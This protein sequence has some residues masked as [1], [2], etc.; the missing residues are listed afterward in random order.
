[1]N[2]PALLHRLTDWL[3]WLSGRREAAIYEHDDFVRA[4]TAQLATRLPLVY[5]VLLTGMLVIALAFRGT[6]PLWLNT[7]IPIALFVFTVL[8]IRAW[9]PRS[10][11]VR[12]IPEQRRRLKSLAFRAATASTLFSCWFIVLYPHGNLHQQSAIHFVIAVVTL[13]GILGLTESPRAAVAVAFCSVAPA[14]VAILYYGHPNAPYITATQL[15]VTMLVLGLSLGHYRNFIAMLEAR[16]K[17]TEREAVAMK[18]AERMR[19]R[20]LVDPLTGYANRRAILD[21]LQ[22][23]LL[24]HSQP[25]PWLGLLDLDGFKAVNDT[26]GHAAGDLVIRQVSDRLA[27]SEDITDFGRLGGDEFALLVD[28]ALSEEEA[29]ATF[30]RIIETIAQPIAAGAT[31]IRITGSIGV[32]KTARMAVSECLERADIALYDAKREPGRAV[33]FS[34]SDE[35]AMQQQRRLASDMREADLDAQIEVDFQPIF[36]FDTRRIIAVEALARWRNERAGIVS[37]AVFIAHAEATGRIG[38]LTWTV[39]V[40]ALAQMKRWPAQTDLQ[41]NLSAFDLANE[42]LADKLREE[43]LR[44]KVPPGRIVLEVT[45]TSVITNLRRASAMLEKLREYGFRIALDDFGTGYSSLAYLQDLPLD[46]IKID[47]EFARHLTKRKRSV[48]IA[49]TIYALAQQL[50]IDCTIEGIESHSQ[51]AI[52]RRI[53]FRK[54]QGFY[55]GKPMSAARLL[56]RFAKEAAPATSPAQARLD[57]AKTA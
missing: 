51:A 48:A 6:G 52:A 38:D 50:D 35:A 42:A 44:R 34:A 26:Y 49:N 46:H 33:I 57:L 47:R 32:R 41:L 3:P 2:T 10:A 25:S 30:T 12:S 22:D 36:D 29:L 16:R 54:M 20:S 55:F 31:T 37:P 56:A 7:G 28:G 9:L 27:Q 19:E 40:K 53:G 18:T 4:H 45:E 43:C 13:T 21:S 24:D 17:L 5:G 8:R 15:F 23:A 11:L 1:M 39:F 14:I